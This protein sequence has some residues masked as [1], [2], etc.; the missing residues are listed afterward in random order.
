M[1]K[2]KWLGIAAVLAAF[3][4]FFKKSKKAEGEKAEPAGE[5]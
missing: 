2:K 5:S 1:V 3:V 4:A